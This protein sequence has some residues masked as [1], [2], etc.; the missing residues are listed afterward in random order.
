M[1][2]LNPTLEERVFSTDRSTFGAI[3]SM[4]GAFGAVVVQQTGREGLYRLERHTTIE[5][6]GS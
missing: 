3:S 6:F 4:I 1:A 2:R 5:A